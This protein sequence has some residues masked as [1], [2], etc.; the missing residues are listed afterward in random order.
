MKQGIEIYRET[1]S[2]FFENINKIDK[3]F[4]KLRKKKEEGHK[5]I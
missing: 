1:K 2:C 5:Y 3:L 4:S